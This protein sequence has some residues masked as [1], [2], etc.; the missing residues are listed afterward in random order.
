ML[1]NRC[2]FFMINSSLCGIGV[3]FIG[4][5]PDAGDSEKLLRYNREF[6]AKLAER[7]I[8]INMR[9]RDK[10][11]AYLQ[12]AQPPPINTGLHELEALWPTDPW[13]FSKDDAIALI[14]RDGLTIIINDTHYVLQN[15]ILG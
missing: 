12:P 10:P 13:L 4:F 3:D 15:A 9:H 8:P 2:A 11:H 5:S 14:K 1:Y 7:T 6:L